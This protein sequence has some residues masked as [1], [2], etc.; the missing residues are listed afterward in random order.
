MISIADFFKKTVWLYLIT[1]IVLLGSL[2]ALITLQLT[3]SEG[4]ARINQVV[5]AQGLVLFPAVV[6]M[7]YFFSYKLSKHSSIEK[8]YNAGMFTYL[9]LVVGWVWVFIG[10]MLLSDTDGILLSM[11]ALSVVS[12]MPWIAQKQYRR[13]L[14]QLYRKN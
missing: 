12:L 8:W 6:V 4:D 13:R 10:K 5:M 7:Y 11:L 2:P 14:A 1:G 3:S 9:V